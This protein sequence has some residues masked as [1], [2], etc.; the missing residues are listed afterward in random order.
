[1]VIFV[2]SD[3]KALPTLSLHPYYTSVYVE[4]Q[5]TFMCEVEIDSTG[6]KYQWFRK[7]LL[8][9]QK[10]DP[11]IMNY[12][13]QS[14]SMKD[15]D[16]FWCRTQRGSYQSEFSRTTKITVVCK[17]KYNTVSTVKIILYFNDPKGRIFLAR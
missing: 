16:E 9:I 15:D 2:L 17:F 13:I 12:T 7:S 3:N 14:V 5:V 6:W 10:T 1:M 11:A 8:Q 4:E